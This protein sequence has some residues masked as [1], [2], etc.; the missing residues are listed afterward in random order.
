MDY[1]F[2]SH[3]DLLQKRGV[4]TFNHELESKSA[5]QLTCRQK[6][7]PSAQEQYR[8]K[9][10]QIGQILAEH[11]ANRG[12]GKS[13]LIAAHAFRDITAQ[14]Q[15]SI[16]F[17]F[18][19]YLD[20]E[21]KRIVINR[22]HLTPDQLQDLTQR[23]GVK[24][25]QGYQ[26]ALLDDQTFTVYALKALLGSDSYLDLLEELSL[27]DQDEVKGAMAAPKLPQGKQGLDRSKVS[28]HTSLKEHSAQKAALLSPSKAKQKLAAQLLQKEETS[29]QMNQERKKKFYRKQEAK[30]IEKKE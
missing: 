14:Y 19:A 22:R 17:N 8:I 16:Q 7:Q 15:I 13:A 20:R 2:S 28:S 26:V 29:L 9:I 30:H 24:D 23:L 27:S 18:N 25:A 11:Q 21:D 1:D 10:G 12:S 3:L 6:L 5:C 4:L